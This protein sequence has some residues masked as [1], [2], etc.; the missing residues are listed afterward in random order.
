MLFS[1]DPRPVIGVYK[2]KRYCVCVCEWG[3]KTD[4]NQPIENIYWNL[5]PQELYKKMNL[6]SI[7]GKYVELYTGDSVI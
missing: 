1:Q 2:Y 4:T 3:K 5:T 6:L 7:I